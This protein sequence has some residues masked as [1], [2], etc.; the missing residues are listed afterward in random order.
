MLNTTKVKIPKKYFEM[1]DSLEQNEEGLYVTKASKGYYFPTVNN[2]IGVAKGHKAIWTIIRWVEEQPKVE[3]VETI[4]E[5]EAEEEKDL[6]EDKTVKELR[7]I[8]KQM[9]LACSKWTKSTLIATIKAV[10]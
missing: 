5:I 10:I 6:F 4:Q 1:V 2:T 9:G 3:Q 7:A 8:G